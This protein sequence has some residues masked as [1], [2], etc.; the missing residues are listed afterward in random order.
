MGARRKS[1][2]P[3]S[4]LYYSD[5]F[6]GS[7]FTFATTGEWEVEV[8]PLIVGQRLVKEKELLETLRTFGIGKE[9]GKRIICRLGC[10]LLNEHEKLFGRYCRLT[11]GPSSSLSQLW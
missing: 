4:S 1:T 9:D 7:L 11:F 5:P 8:V 6:L 3:D 2:E 10:T